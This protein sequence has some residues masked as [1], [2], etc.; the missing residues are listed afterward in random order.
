VE[1]IGW[2]PLDGGPLLFAGRL[3]P[4][5]GTLEAIEIA[6]GAGRELV[7][8][9]GPYD[10]VYDA[11]V[12][13]AASSGPGVTLAGAIARPALWELMARSA[14]LLF[15]IVWEEPF[16][17]VVAEAQAAGCPVVGFRRGALT[18]L[19]DDGVTGA[20]VAP[21]DVRAA[22]AALDH[23][24]RWDRAACR[25]HAERTLDVAPMVA[26]YLSLYEGA[27]AGAAAGAAR[28]AAARG[29]LS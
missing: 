5:K 29:G 24:E 23:M 10:P 26:A 8:A 18:E 12:E 22:A 16:G 13:R 1:R 6:R 3:S 4:E 19:I 2:S 28:P 21:G 17:L 7:I 9:G 20:A 15:P 11:T 14:A 25:R 27:V